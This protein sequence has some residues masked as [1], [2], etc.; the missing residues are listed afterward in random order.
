M[1]CNPNST[2]CDGNS[3]M[4]CNEDGTASMLSMECEEDTQCVAGECLG[5]CDLIAYEQSNIG[6]RFWAVSNVNELLNPAFANDFGIAIGNPETNPDAMVTIKRDGV[7]VASEVV[8]SGSTSAITLPM[9]T[10]L[11]TATQSVIQSQGAYE[12]ET[13]VPVAAYQYSPL[14]F[15]AP[16]G[17]QCT[18]TADCPDPNRQECTGGECMVF[19]YTNDASLLLPEHVLTGNYMV[20]TWPTWG[21]YD[22]EYTFIVT[23]PPS[24]RWFSGFITIVGTADATDVTL[25][26]KN[27]TAGGNPSALNEGEQTTFTLNKGDVAQVLSY[28]PNID[29]TAANCTGQG[30]PNTTIPG[31]LKPN[32]T[33]CSAMSGD[34]T[35]STVA[36]TAPVAVFA[37]HTC[38]NLPYGSQ[39]CD[40]LEEMM[41]PVETWGL[42]II[43]TA[44]RPPNATQGVAETLYRVVALGD[45]TSVAFDPP[46]TTSPVTLQAG[47]VH[48]FTTDKDFVAAGNARIS[49]TQGML[50]ALYLNSGT[51][52]DPAMGMGIPLQ[53]HRSRYDFLTPDTYESNWVNIVVPSGGTILLDDSTLTVFEAVGSTGYDVARVSLEPGSHH[54]ESG[55]DV[56]F[57]ITSYGYAQF[58]SYLFPG[59]LNFK[60]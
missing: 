48:E 44:P 47:E 50:G 22:E 37:G 36:A 52:G 8:P 41:F 12:I 21:S 38:T 23:L 39:A 9:V 57:S 15:T 35:G 30:W 7:E 28:V 40:H 16:L 26:S 10:E 43:M 34:L 33:Y 5:I 55:G 27:K 46:V 17:I 58:T 13:S 19:S 59:G 49:I 31:I 54:I 45:N 24:G 1:I 29:G 14:N 11:R 25:T 6:C 20:T 3:V 56:P 51:S 4:Q 32:R 42:E 60:Q 2:F 53:Q 18:T